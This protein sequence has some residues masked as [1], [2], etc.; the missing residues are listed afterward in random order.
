MTLPIFLEIVIGLVFVYLVLS[1]LA[2]E[3]QELISTI[4]QWRAQHLKDSIINLLS[5]DNASDSNVKSAQELAQQIYEHPAL[6]SINQEAKGFFALLFRSLTW[7]PAYVYRLITGHD[8]EFGSQRTAPSYI[9]ASAFSRSLISQLGT[10]HLIEKLQQAKFLAFHD[11]II[12]NVKLTTGLSNE[13]IINSSENKL[14]E[15]RKKF[16]VH[17]HS[18]EEAVY[19]TASELDNLIETL[20]TSDKLSNKEHDRLVDW[21]KSLFEE[22]DGVITLGNSLKPTLYEIVEAL[23]PGSR[24][25]KAYEKNFQ[26]YDKTRLEEAQKEIEEFKILLSNCFRGMPGSDCLVFTNPIIKSEITED[27]PPLELSFSLYELPKNI[28]EKLDDIDE[29]FTGVDRE[30][31]KKY[32]HLKAFKAGFSGYRGERSKESI[33]WGAKKLLVIIGL[34]L[35]GVL[36]TL[37]VVDG[38]LSSVSEMPKGIV[39][40]LVWIIIFFASSFVVNKIDQKKK[41]GKEINTTQITH[42]QQVISNHA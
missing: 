33:V 6:T 7:I 11:S 5:G 4:L 1:L 41:R 3:I 22:K 34:I 31:G 10:R 8:S 36:V 30:K 26:N 21:K 38:N 24:I 18:L 32:K 12:D 16:E 9:P 20:K 19:K 28:K 17:K 13:R 15:I 14:E 40:L 39:F 25:Y 29:A 2:A 42:A 23:N 27:T 37:L 35:T